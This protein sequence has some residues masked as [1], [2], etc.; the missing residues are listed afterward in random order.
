[1]PKGRSRARGDAAPGGLTFLELVLAGSLMVGLLAALGTVAT[2]T[3]GQ[4]AMNR[5]RLAIHLSLD[6]A[7]EDIRSRTFSAIRLD[8]DSMFN[9]GAE[10]VKEDLRFR[11][12]R[13]LHHLTPDDLS[14]NRW[15]QYH[16]IP[17]RDYPDSPG[18]LVLVLGL[19]PEDPDLAR[20]I[21]VPARYNP[22]IRFIHKAEYPPDFL[23]VEITA[24]DDHFDIQVAKTVGLN[25]W[26]LSVVKVQ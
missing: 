10:V 11:G 5:Q 8:D 26:Y 25:F 19:G 1:M 2:L 15:Y 17:D 7:L 3:A 4:V 9:A 13:D 18:N 21:L 14:D 16:I 24:R 23:L 20:E 12:E 22:T 6:Y